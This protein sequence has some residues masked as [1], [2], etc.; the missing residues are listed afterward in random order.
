MYAF[1][2]TAKSIGRHRGVAVTAAA[3]VSSRYQQAMMQI[4]GA[5][6]CLFA[7]VLP[8]STTLAAI[9]FWLGAAVILASGVWRQCRWSWLSNPA[10]WFLGLTY[11]WLLLAGSYTVAPTEQL[12]SFLLKMSRMLIAVVYLPLFMQGPWS[13]RVIMAFILSM[14]L[15]LLLIYLKVYA[16]IFIPLSYANATYDTV[17]KSHIIQSYLM[18]VACFYLLLQWR[19]CRGWHRFG[20]MALVVMMA[21]YLVVISTSRTGLLLFV[22]MALYAFARFLSPKGILI[23][24]VAMVVALAAAVMVSQNLQAQLARVMHSV[25]AFYHMGNTKTS[26]GF[27]LGLMHRSITMINQKPW[28]GYG[29]AG[30]QPAFEQ[31]NRCNP[32]APMVYSKNTSNTYLNMAFQLGWPGLAFYLTLLVVLWLYGSQLSSDNCYCL[33]LTLIALMV[34]GFFNAW[35]VDTVEAHWSVFSLVLFYAPWSLR[36]N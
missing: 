36:R 3:F 28:F 16:G 23:A 21:F 5:L 22:V 24:V 6:A 1:I 7:F 30:F 27:R 26:A 20:V 14:L 11:L 35:L 34:G 8:I 13:R 29:T 2:D 31:Y 15:T 12:C 9:A 33:R 25:S 32:T 18:N 19:D 4:A 10:V 17:F